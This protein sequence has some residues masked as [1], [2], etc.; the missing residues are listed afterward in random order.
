MKKTFVLCDSNTINSYGF[1][2][3]LEGMNL[4]RFRSNPVMLYQ[5]DKFSVIGRWENIRIEDGRLL[6]DAKFDSE[7]ELARQVEGKIRN[8]FKE[9][10]KHIGGFVNFNTLLV[11]EG[12]FDEKS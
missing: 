7:D 6:A 2:I 11:A 1:R 10:A 5:H 4:D 12:V 3:R 9:G 8:F